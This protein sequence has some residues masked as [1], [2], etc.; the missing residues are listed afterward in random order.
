M[1]DAYFPGSIVLVTGGATNL[2]LDRAASA[3]EGNALLSWLL[4]PVLL[5]QS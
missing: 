2:L 5:S 4:V 3:G 1:G